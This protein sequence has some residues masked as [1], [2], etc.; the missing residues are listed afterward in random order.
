MNEL[1]ES[2]SCG[3]RSVMRESAEQEEQSETVRYV[4]CQQVS[5]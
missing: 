3:G 5:G 2:G 1:R 4:R